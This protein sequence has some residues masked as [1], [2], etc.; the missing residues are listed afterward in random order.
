M[1]IVH[2]VHLVPMHSPHQ[3]QDIQT[4][5]LSVHAG[6]MAA[7]A[8]TLRQQ[9]L[10]AIKAAGITAMSSAG[11]R[12]NDV[13][14]SMLASVSGV[15]ESVN[16]D[17]LEG[18]TVAMELAH[19]VCML[20]VWLVCVVGC[21]WW[22]AVCPTNCIIPL[23]CPHHGHPQNTQANTK[24]EELKAAMEVVSKS[25]EA[26]LQATPEHPVPESTATDEG[27]SDKGA[28]PVSTNGVPSSNGAAP[29][30]SESNGAQ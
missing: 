12:D 24:V 1:C 28:S 15:T 3:Q 30:S 8:A 14:G 22:G 9:Q 5:T 23:V 21:V 7:E 18:C 4:H 16:E 26:A 25:A 2:I 11:V 13:V 27:P 10:N 20:G 17:L 29:S 6:V 19:E